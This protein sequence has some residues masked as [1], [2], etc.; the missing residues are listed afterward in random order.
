LGGVIIV[1]SSLFVIIIGSAITFFIGGV[2]RYIGVLG[3]FCSCL[4]IY[5]ALK[6]RT[7]PK[8]HVAYGSM[9]LVD[10]FISW[11]GAFGG[12]GIGFLLALLGGVL[13]IRWK[14]PIRE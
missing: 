1:L 7:E 5:S 13:G 12:F 14:I 8:M 10:S 3:I 4:I 9:I 11:I 6:L 2:G